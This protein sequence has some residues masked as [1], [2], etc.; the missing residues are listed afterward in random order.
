MHTNFMS[1]VSVHLVNKVHIIINYS[2]VKIFDFETFLTE[3]H[4]VAVRLAK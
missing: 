3:T 2:Y 1:F 4:C